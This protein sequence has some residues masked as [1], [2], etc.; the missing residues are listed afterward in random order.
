MAL[1]F[2]V[3]PVL[4]HLTCQEEIS[5]TNQLF[6]YG[7]VLNGIIGV[8]ISS[9]NSGLIANDSFRKFCAFA[10]SKTNSLFSGRVSDGYSSQMF[11]NV[12]VKSRLKYTNLMLHCIFSCVNFSDSDGAAFLNASG[13]GKY[14]CAS[15]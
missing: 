15:G 4:M 5:Y 3:T 8:K 10:L 6:T 7:S 13:H 9:M 14:K 11:E 1:L 12:K 2:N